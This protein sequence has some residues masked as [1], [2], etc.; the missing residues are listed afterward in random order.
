M[1][2]PD[3]F[4]SGFIGLLFLSVAMDRFDFFAV[5]QFILVQEK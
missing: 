3:V 1:V 4:L 5:P 2:F